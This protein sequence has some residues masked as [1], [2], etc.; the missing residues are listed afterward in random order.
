MVL[1]IFDTINFV[2]T[3]FRLEY[4]TVQLATNFKTLSTIMELELRLDLIIVFFLGCLICYL[5][6]LAQYTQNNLLS[7]VYVNITRFVKKMT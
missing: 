1:S 4:F 6:E 7:V 2:V 5:L 3:T